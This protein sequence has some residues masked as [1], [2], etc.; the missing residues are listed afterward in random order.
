[1]VVT[2]IWVGNKFII[3]FWWAMFITIVV[4]QKTL[5]QTLK[6]RRKEIY[7]NSLKLKYLQW[8]QNNKRFIVSQLSKTKK[9][10]TKYL[11]II[12]NTLIAHVLRIHILYF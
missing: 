8:I 4:K 11:L 5:Q 9:L 1:M 3:C 12:Q 6:P 10:P 2:K 7:I